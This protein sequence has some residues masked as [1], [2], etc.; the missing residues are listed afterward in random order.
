MPFVEATGHESAGDWEKYARKWG[1]DAPVVNVSWRDANAY[2]EWAGVRLPTEAEWE[3][4]ARGTDART[5]PWGNHLNQNLLSREAQVRP[6]AVGT[7][8]QGASPYGAQDMAGSVW[9]WCSTEYRPTAYNAQD[10]REDENPQ[11]TCDRTLRGGSWFNYDAAILRSAY[12]YDFHP[13]DYCN[14]VG[15][16]VARSAPG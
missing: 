12:R 15:F 2:C 4:A 5:Y 1:E 7:H 16:R 14:D 11:A 9:Q 10:G 8:P 3:K 6:A 13:D